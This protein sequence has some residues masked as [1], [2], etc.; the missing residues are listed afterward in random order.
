MVLRRAVLILSAAMETFVSL[1]MSKKNRM[2]AEVVHLELYVVP[3]RHRRDFLKSLRGPVKV[4][5][6]IERRRGGSGP[7]F[8]RVDVQRR[9]YTAPSI[10]SLLG[11]RQDEDLWVEIA[12]YP[13]W[14]QRH[15]AMRKIWSNL[16]I[17][18]SLEDTD[19]FVSRGRRSYGVAEAQRII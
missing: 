6:T 8:Y 17:T 18:A 1:I 19:R 9:S 3:R 12:T 16:Q 15:L 7:L 2:P 10:G 13:S 11:V 4:A 14:K 5:R